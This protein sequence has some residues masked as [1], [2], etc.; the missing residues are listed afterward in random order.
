MRK[1]AFFVSLALLASVLAAQTPSIQANGSATINVNPDQAQLT[2]GV[3]TQ[4]PTAQSAADQNAAKTNAVIEA[5]KAVLGGSGTIQTVNYS[6][7]PN[8]NTGS[9]LVGYTVTNTLQV[10]TADLTLPGPLIDAGNRAGAT[11]VGGLSFGLRDADPFRQQMLTQAG[12]QALAHAAAIASGLGVK[13]GAILSA[14]EGASV[15]PYT[16]GIGVA[17]STPI[18]T[19]TVSV[20]ATV[21][22]SIQL[23]Q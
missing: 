1:S 6:V 13:T 16:G 14:S 12:K 19:G 11:N 17:A 18:L 4:A 10:V 21:S 23:V 3:T 15:T 22:V 8:Y 20:T 5:L 7:Y 9:V 2:V